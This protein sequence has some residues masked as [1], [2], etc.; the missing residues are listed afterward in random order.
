MH[1]RRVS[2]EKTESEL[3]TREAITSLTCEMR[4]LQ[5][6]C[7][8]ATV[9]GI[10]CTVGYVEMNAISKRF[11]T[12]RLGALYVTVTVI[13]G[14]A[15]M[16]VLCYM[17]LPLDSVGNAGNSGLRKGRKTCRAKEEKIT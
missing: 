12:T 11:G 2:Q 13:C 5:T 9:Y 1:A 17:Y 4:L 6:C 8:P 15:C 10:A 14:D 3:F 16:Y 7:G